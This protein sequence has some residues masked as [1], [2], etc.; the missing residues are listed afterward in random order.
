MALL[1]LIVSSSVYFEALLL[2]SFIT[3]IEELNF[4][5]EILPSKLSTTS[6]N[7]K[8]NFNIGL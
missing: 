8:L 7:G 2:L 4:W 1:L 3:R 5:W 6:N